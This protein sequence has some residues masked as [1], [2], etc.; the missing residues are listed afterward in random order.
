MPRRGAAPAAGLWGSSTASLAASS[1]IGPA[2]RS[3]QLNQSA[4]AGKD[5]DP[6]AVLL[7]LLDGDVLR[8]RDGSAVVVIQR[9]ID[10]DA[11][12]RPNHGAASPPGASAV[13]RPRR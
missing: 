3:T 1:R 13:A 2:P 8:L 10:F 4:P 6:C 7:V 9:Q 12:H 11:S 5:R